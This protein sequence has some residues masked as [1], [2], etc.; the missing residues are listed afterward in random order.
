[1]EKNV[2][3]PNDELK[4]E[5]VVMN[6]KELDMSQLGNFE[7]YK[8]F[9]QK[10]VDEVKGIKLTDTNLP[11]VKAVKSLIVS[12]RTNTTKIQK[13][14]IAFNINSRK[15]IAN[16]SFES[17]LSV[18]AESEKQID[19]E[20]NKYEEERR[21]GL[22]FMFETYIAEQNETFK[23][24]EKNL[25]RI[26]IKSNYFNVT[27]KEADVFNDITSQFVA[28]KK[29]LDEKAEAETAIKKECE[30]STLNADVY[31]EMLSF[32]TPL[33]IISQIKEEKERV[34][35]LEEEKIAK[36][37][38]EKEAEIEKEVVER[39]TEKENVIEFPE[40]KFNANVVEFPEAKF[41]AVEEFEEEVVT[42][43]VDKTKT[44]SVKLTYKE[45]QARMINDFFKNNNIKVD[46]L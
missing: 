26:E 35:K 45:S 28:I 23:L 3:A 8:A 42:D 6:D 17:I 33:S 1:M 16:A 37:V 14:W 31:I 13:D 19:D 7:E 21:A 44:L 9:I 2:I 5:L 32:K 11:E 43:E 46:V 25:E 18:I 39:L 12:L 36:A 27:K 20:L 30:G 22:L 40:A 41:N 38:A 34:A 24:D 29:E 4:T 15:N 10:K